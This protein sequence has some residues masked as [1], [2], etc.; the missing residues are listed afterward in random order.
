[1]I[2]SLKLSSLSSISTYIP[3]STSLPSEQK[4]MVKITSVR[5]LNAQLVR[6]HP[7]VAAFVGGTAGI[8]EFTVRA[9][10]A[11]YAAHSTLPMRAYLVGRNRVAGEKICAECKEVYPRGEYIFVQA[12]DLA[13]LRDVDRVCEEI[14]EQERAREEE[15]GRVEGGVVKSERIGRARIDFLV[16]TQGVLTFSRNG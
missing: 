10:A 4:T 7:L 15:E 16:M 2:F 5:S 14:G 9:L 13:L 11:T 3:P 12:K 8:G 6:E 1:M